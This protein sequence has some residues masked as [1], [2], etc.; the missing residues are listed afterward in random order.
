[1]NKKTVWVVLSVAIVAGA[2]WYVYKK[3]LLVSPSVTQGAA[4]VT[5]VPL[6]VSIL[7][8]P[9]S[10]ALTKKITFTARASG[11]VPPYTYAW[12]FSNGIGASG[13]YGTWTVA[14]PLGLQPVNVAVKDATGKVALADTKINVIWPIG[15]KIYS[16]LNNNSPK[17]RIVQ[18]SVSAVTKDVVLGIFDFTAD[19]EVFLTNVSFLN[20][21][22]RSFSNFKLYD[23]QGNLVGSGK[24]YEG[25]IVFNGMSVSLG[26]R[27][28]PLTLKADVKGSGGTF[29]S[30]ATLAID[31]VSG[32][33]P[34]GTMKAINA[35]TYYP[36]AFKVTFSPSLP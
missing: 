13:E 12:M 36:K 3:G 19:K 26:A 1:M 17:D 25:G 34:P 21:A 16:R 6:S 8:G 27:W 23:S 31:G 2:G 24:V 33:V 29:S 15:A 20:S 35:N 5:A 30:E 9:T 7:P 18:T 28:V 11:G 14:K 22:N 4:V 32:A 10:A